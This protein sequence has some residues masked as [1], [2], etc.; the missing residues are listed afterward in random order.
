V[1][2]PEAG[3]PKRPRGHQTAIV[4]NRMDFAC[5]ISQTRAELGLLLHCRPLADSVFGLHAGR[6]FVP[7]HERHFSAMTEKQPSQPV[8]LERVIEKLDAVCKTLDSISL[9]SGVRGS[10]PSLYTFDQAAELLGVKR[11]TVAKLVA[12]K[13]L[14]CVNVS[15]S[16]TCRRPRRRIWTSDLL[17]F[18]E[19]RRVVAIPTIAEV[20]RRR[21]RSRE[22][23]RAKK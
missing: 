14:A 4:S 20:R 11:A 7:Q 17:A 16:L 2:G 8:T 18:L 15:L 10:G 5:A 22:A 3:D 9:Y 1:E 23:S 6:R 21:R 19:E 12:R 13:Q